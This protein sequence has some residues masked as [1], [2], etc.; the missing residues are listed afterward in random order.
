[1]LQTD[2]AIYTDLILDLNR[3]P[4]NKG[5]MDDADITHSG[6]NILCGDHVRIYLKLNAAKRVARASFE[7]NGCAISIAAASLITE[8]AKWKIPEEILALQKEDVFELLG[9]PLGPSRLKCGMLSLETMQEG[10]RGYLA[11][12]S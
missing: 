3:H 8:E 10:I 5:V 11:K 7:G 4:L 6:V 2:D 9:T 12:T 1:M